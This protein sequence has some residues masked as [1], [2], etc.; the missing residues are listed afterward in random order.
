MGISIKIEPEAFQ[1]IQEAVSWY[2]E[3]QYGLGQS[4]FQEKLKKVSKRLR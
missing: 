4:F 1:D 3:K 2:N